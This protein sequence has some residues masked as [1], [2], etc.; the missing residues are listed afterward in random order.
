MTDRML[1]EAVLATPVTG[2][3]LRPGTLADQ[4]DVGQPTLFVF[5]RHLG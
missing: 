3:H 5:L 1:P 2:R 4:L